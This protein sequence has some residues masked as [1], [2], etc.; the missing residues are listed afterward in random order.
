MPTPETPTNPA[1][2]A[3]WRQ[4]ADEGIEHG[5]DWPYIVRVLF[6]EL[7]RLRAWKQEATPLLDGLQ[8]LGRALDL[9]LGVLVT[10]PLAVE[11]ANKLRAQRDIA[12]SALTARE[13]KDG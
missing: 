9:P 7:D 12:R 6:R 2:L 4:L 5:T 10:G 8:D 11:A 3:L 13:A 1:L